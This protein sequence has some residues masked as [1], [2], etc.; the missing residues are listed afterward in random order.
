M[1]DATIF[2]TIAFAIVWMQRKKRWSNFFK[3]LEGTAVLGS[4][5]SL[6]SGASAPAPPTEG[7][8]PGNEPTSPGGSNSFPTLPGI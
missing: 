7:V 1:S 6:G 4:S 2:V 8:N 5:P 3:A